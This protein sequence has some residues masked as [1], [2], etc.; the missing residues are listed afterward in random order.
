MQAFRLCGVELG[1]RGNTTEVLEISMVVWLW[2]PSFGM[3]DVCPPI[4]VW[5]L[6]A[7]AD[8]FHEVEIIWDFNVQEHQPEGSW[9]LNLF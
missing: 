5:G 8:F 2:V 7:R 1:V 4:A 3:K 6:G 9:Q